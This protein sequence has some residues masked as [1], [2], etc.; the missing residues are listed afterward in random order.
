[1]ATL[2]I[3]DFR[4]I[5]LQQYQKKIHDIT[6]DYS[7]LVD[8]NAEYSWFSTHAIAQLPLSTQGLKDVVIMLGFNDC[9][10][11]CVWEAA[12][13]TKQLAS[14]YAKTIN[15]LITQYQSLNFYVCSINPIDADYPFAESDDG[16]ISKDDLTAKIKLF[17]NYIKNNRRSFL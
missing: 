1:M 2:I 17:N 11:S 12:F 16:I 7:Y 10:Y 3:G 8:E 4:G 13:N 9:V 5:T 6:L 14:D 15:E